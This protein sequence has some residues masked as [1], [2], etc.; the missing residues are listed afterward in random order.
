MTNLMYHLTLQLNLVTKHHQD[1]SSFTKHHR[2]NQRL[3][4]YREKRD[5]LFFLELLLVKTVATKLFH[6]MLL[7]PKEQSRKGV[8]V[9]HSPITPL[10]LTPCCATALCLVWTGPLAADPKAS[11]LA[12]TD[13]S[14]KT[15]LRAMIIVVV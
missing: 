1:A 7:Q 11:C 2:P 10:S 15:L 5:A 12:V 8:P 13:Q 6:I 9:T 3:S 4:D 14:F